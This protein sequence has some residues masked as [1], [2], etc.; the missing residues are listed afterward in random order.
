MNQY[1]LL[2]II[3]AKHTEEEIGGLIEKVNGIVKTAGAEIKE[4]HQLGRRR[5][6]YPINDVRNGVYVLS[7][8]EA[9]PDL[10]DK[11][12]QTLRLS[13][14]LLRHLIVE[15]DPRLTKIP[16]LI[17]TDDRRRPGRPR[18]GQQRQEQ[19]QQ[20]PMTKKAEDI[21]MK[22]L[23]KKLDEILTEEVL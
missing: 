15:R 1:E 10:I 12:N 14:E 2:F 17:E 16:S 6:A 11:I 21:N 20:R 19:T 22:E 4:T 23:D 18:E 5:L 8:F 13:T 9:A 7:Y 3:P